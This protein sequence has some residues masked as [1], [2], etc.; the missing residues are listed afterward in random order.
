VYVKDAFGVR[1][2]ELPDPRDAFCAEIN[3][4]SA[5]TGIVASVSPFRRPLG[6]PAPLSALRKSAPKK[7]GRVR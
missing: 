1:Q 3:R 6:V 7:A 2:V 5:S 4:L